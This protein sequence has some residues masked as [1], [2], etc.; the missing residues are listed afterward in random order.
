MAT[1]RSG[2][3]WNLAERSNFWHDLAV[4]SAFLCLFPSVIINGKVILALQIRRGHFQWTAGSLVAGSLMNGLTPP[5]L[6]LSFDH[7]VVDGA[8][9]V[10]FLNTFIERLE[11]PDLVLLEG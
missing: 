10:L 9:A 4:G 11:D 6:S 3:R 1:F 8:E 7:R 5:L 2:A